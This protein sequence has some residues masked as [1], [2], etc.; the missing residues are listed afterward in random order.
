MVPHYYNLRSDHLVGYIDRHNYFGE[1]LGDSMLA[2]PGSG[3]FS[4]RAGS[5]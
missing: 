5:S 1:K 2:R 3:Y 4:G